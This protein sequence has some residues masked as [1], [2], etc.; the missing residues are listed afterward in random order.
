MLNVFEREAV[1]EILRGYL[2]VG[3]LGLHLWRKFRRRALHKVGEVVV[4]DLLDARQH[5]GCRERRN[6]EVCMMI[7]V[8]VF[9]VV[10]LKVGVDKVAIAEKR[11]VLGC[12]VFD[13]VQRCR[14]LHKS[15][16][17]GKVQSV[18]CRR[19]STRISVTLKDTWRV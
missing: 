19:T 18:L 2:L 15:Q 10:D 8:E 16:A 17:M 11:C 1:G 5:R 7:E 12:V 9:I 4:V 14:K 13:G 6:F 3:R